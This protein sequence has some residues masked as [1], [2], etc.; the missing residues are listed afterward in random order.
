MAKDADK[1]QYLLSSVNN[2]LGLLDVLSH[3]SSLT[4]AELQRETG[5][6]KARLFRMLYTLEK[7]GLVS[8]DANARYSLGLKLLH[9]GGIVASRQDVVQV[10]QGPM[11]RFCQ[12]TG[13]SSH[14]TRRNDTRVV[15]VHIED[16]V[17]GMCVTARVGM[18]APIYATAGGRA[19]LANLPEDELLRILSDVEFKQYS[20]NSVKGVSDLYALLDDV[21]SC[22]YADDIDDRYQGFGSLAA[23]VFNHTGE[24]VAAVGLVTLSSNVM[25]GRD[26]YSQE[27]LALAEEISRGMGNES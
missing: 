7:N 10:A 27:L 5:Y 9:Y 17:D 13:L 18:S 14:L 6:D 4:L 16:P 23:P 25:R 11:R 15:T 1:D 21:R 20:Q 2:T 24:C 8:K 12:R 19:I 3:H 22:G 26:R